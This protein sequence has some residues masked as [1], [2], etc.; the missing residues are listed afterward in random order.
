MIGTVLAFYSN[1]YYNLFVITRK[2]S[3]K[4]I[5]MTTDFA[6]LLKKADIGEKKLNVA[7]REILT[8]NVISLGRKVFKKRI[9]S[10]FGGKRGG[11]RSILYYQIDQVVIF[12][13]LYAKNEQEEITE[14]EKKAFI[15]LAGAFEKMDALTLHKAISENKLVRLDYAE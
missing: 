9:G 2:I 8:G 11:Y 10:R 15:Q 4:L 6:R 13:Y 1:I 7:I 12:M 14:R 5:C 3:L